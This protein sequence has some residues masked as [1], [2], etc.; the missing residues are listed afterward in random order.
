MLLDPLIGLALGIDE[1]RPPLA[2]GG[3]HSVVDAQC[4]VGQSF[5]DPFSD[6]QRC[7]QSFGER[8]IFREGN[9][10]FRELFLPAVENGLA[11]CAC[12]WSKVGNGSG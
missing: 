1:E 2:L 10:E 12:E 9:A 8:V 3:N 11:I 4:I 5:D 7:L 6:G